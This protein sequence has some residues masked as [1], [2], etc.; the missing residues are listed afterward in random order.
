MV[1]LI[2]GQDRFIIEKMINKEVRKILGEVD[3]LNFVKFDCKEAD[4]TT[5]MTDLDYLPLGVT[6]KVVLVD[7]VDYFDKKSSLSKTEESELMSIING[8]KDDLYLLLIVRDQINKKHTLIKLIE[9]YGRIFEIA[10]VSPEQLPDLVTTLFTKANKTIE[11]DAIQLLIEFTQANTM[12]LYNEIE[13]LMLYKDT[14]NREDVLELVARPFEESIFQLSN[15]LIANDKSQALQI[16]R[17]FQ[18]MNV[19]PLTFIANLANQFRL[20]ASVFLLAD[21]R[22]GKD[23]IATE[24]GVH[25][26]RVQLA[27]R[28][29][30][31]LTLNEIYEVLDDLHTLDYKIKSGQIDRFYAFEMFLINY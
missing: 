20:Y 3:A 8:K 19:E 6:N 24:L 2:Y 25:P 31:K 9:Q 29:R 11:A 30:Q 5:I 13:K 22:L 27:L 21:K 4:F 18:T 28:M 17:D 7:N 23:D 16:Y 15:A 10:P 14:I 1:Y 26:Y 12:A